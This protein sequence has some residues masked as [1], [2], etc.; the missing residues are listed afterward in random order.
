MWMRFI[1]TLRCPSCTGRLGLTVF[2]QVEV[3]IADDAR[4]LAAERH[5]LDDRFNR[6]VESGVLL[7][8]PCKAMFPIIDGLP[9]LLCYTTPLHREF[10]SR[11]TGPAMEPFAAYRFL[12]QEPASGERAVMQSFS[13]EWLDYDYD[14]VIWELSYDDQERRLIKEMGPALTEP[15]NRTFLEVGCGLGITTYLAHKQS[16]ADAV[17]LDLSLAVW[18]AAR[19]Y[20]TN[21]FLHF[22]EASVFAMPFAQGAFDLVYSRGVLHHTVSTEKAFESVSRVCRPGGTLYLWIY[23]LGSIQETVFRRVIYGL[24]RAFR[25]ALSNA[26]DSLAAKTFLT[27]MGAGYVVF[28]GLRRAFNREIQPLTLARGVHAARD[29]FTP[30]YAHRHEAGEVTQWFRRAGFAQTEIL[31]WRIMPPAEHDDYRRNIGVRGKL[32]DATT[33]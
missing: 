5:L 18:K 9:V 8:D 13:K 1:D 32:A 16:G 24:E 33:A 15:G 6:Y 4:A 31:D 2:E 27:A 28:N 29:R 26:P 22:V 23:G 11:H 30:R 7:C 20:R 19:H 10:L 14:G 17:G 25:P 21:P 12:E 3:P